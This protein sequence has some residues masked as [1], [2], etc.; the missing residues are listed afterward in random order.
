M[1]AKAFLPLAAALF[2]ILP[3]CDKPAK[4]PGTTQG[5]I[6]PTAYTNFSG[7]RAME[8]VKA[9]V[10]IGPRPS[11]SEG[12]EKS[13]VYIEQKLKEAG[14][15]MKR[16]DFEVDTILRGKIKMSNL[17]ARFPVPGKNTWKRSVT[18]LAC[19]HYDTKWFQTTVFVGANDAGSSTGLLLELAR[20]TAPLKDFSAS[21]ELLFFD[22]EEAITGFTAPVGFSDTRFDGLYG[23]RHYAKELRKVP[24]NQ[25]PKYGIVFDIIGGEPLEVEF[26]DNTSKRLS[27]LAREASDALNFSKHFRAAPA[28]AAMIDDHVPLSWVGME[29]LNFISLG[30]FREYWH[31][32]A[33]TIDKVFPKSIEITGRTGLYFME[34]NLQQ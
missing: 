2:A 4:P 29:V 26:P 3:G 31:T 30:P 10:A 19:S 34:R 6:K 21:L 28:G 1:K 9:I 22:G 24:E 11:G 16:Q 5:A 14:W 15:E 25:R 20:A 7:D 23:S 32:S 12:I 18:T 17:R 27:A 8:D 13:R 33:D